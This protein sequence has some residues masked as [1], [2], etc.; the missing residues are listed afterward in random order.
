MIDRK[1]KTYVAGHR[2]LVGSAIVNRLQTEGFTN[3]VT[4][5]HDQL[6][7]R[8]QKEVCKFFQ[9]E[10]PDYVFLCA[11]KVGGIVAHLNKPVDFL[12][13]NLAIQ[14]NVLQ[15]A[16]QFGTR[17]L[18]FLGS[19]CAYPKHAPNPIKEEYLLD[20]ILEPSNRGYALA[21]LAG[22]EACKAYRK[23]HGRDFISCMPTNLYGLGDNYHPENSHVIPGMIGKIHRAFRRDL[24]TVNLWGSGKPVREF[25]FSYDMADACLFLMDYYNGADTI[26]IGSGCPLHLSDL[27]DTIAQVIGYTGQIFWDTSKP[28]GTPW[29]ELDNSKLFKLGWRPTVTLEDGL[30]TAY[31]DFLCRQ[32]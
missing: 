4:R 20:G 25:L 22:I 2:G 28:D 15:A 3:I 18:L 27:A 17:K 10:H 16:H 9:D 19:A 13:D 23:Q 14:T 31:K 6:D 24:P 7:L 26:N 29:R 21:K 32:P 11:A 30:C 8:Y 1:A 12:V 5:T